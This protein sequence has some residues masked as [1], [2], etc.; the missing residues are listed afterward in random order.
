MAD[1]DPPVLGFSA[2]SGTGK[3]TLLTRLLPLLRERGLRIAVVKHAHHSFDLDQPGKDSYELRKAGAHQ[4]VVTSRRRTAIIHEHGDDGPEPRLADALA[5]VDPR[6]MDLVLVEG[7]KHEDFPKI[8]LHR[9]ALGQPLICADNPS[10]IAVASDEPVS[11]PRGL[12]LLDLN[13]PEAIAEF[14]W[15]WHA[16]ATG[17]S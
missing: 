4:M 9:P 8:E 12:P 6:G 3:T 5:R 1:P 10:V 7:F 16:R 17:Q 13:R 11:L 14:I 15:A 2:F